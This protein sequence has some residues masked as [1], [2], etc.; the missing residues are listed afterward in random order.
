MEFINKCKL[1]DKKK[2]HCTWEIYTMRNNLKSLR[3]KFREINKF[4]KETFFND[5]NYRK[6]FIF[7]KVG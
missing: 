7:V 3:L 6:V 5:W 2:S 4:N 1:S